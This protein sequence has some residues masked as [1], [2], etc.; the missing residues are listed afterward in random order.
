MR[1]IRRLVPLVVV[2]ATVVAGAPAPALA[3]KQAPLVTKVYLV[4]QSNGKVPPCTFTAAELKQALKDV[5][6]D[7]QQYA[8]DFEDAIKV[9][10]EARA[11]GACGKKGSSG[12]QTSTTP[13]ATGTSGSGSGSG[14]ATTTTSPANTS[15]GTQPGATT[16]APATTGTTPQPAPT[17]DPAPAVN[18]DAI[19]SAA[20][21]PVASGA[22]DAPAPLLVLAVMLGTLL[23][24]A[25]LWLAARWLGFDPPW[26][27]R[28]RH[29]TQEAGWRASAAWSEFTDWVRLGR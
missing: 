21:G 10:L 19:P 4:Y 14:G 6:P 5:T 26:L 17:V 29:A 12:T 7:I 11:T 8:P 20:T 25:G 27:A 3:K 15:T 16:T 1:R 18:D 23:V 9:A 28:W 2:A 22:D 13:A 24:L